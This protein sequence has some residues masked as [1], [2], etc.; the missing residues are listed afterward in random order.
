MLAVRRQSKSAQDF[1]Y[2]DDI[3]YRL[4]GRLIEQLSSSICNFPP[5]VWPPPVNKHRQAKV[6]VLSVHMQCARSVLMAICAL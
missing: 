1:S 2:R 4:W 5:L 6:V 3:D